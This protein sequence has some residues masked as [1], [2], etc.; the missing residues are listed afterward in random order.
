[1]VLI[2]GRAFLEGP[3]W[4]HGRLWLSDVPTGEVL[5][6]D[7]DGKVEVVAAIDG[8]PSGLG[9]LPDGTLLV[10]RGEPAAIMAVSPGGQVGVYVDLT[11]VASFAP[12]DMVVD[13]SGRA[14]VGTCDLAGIPSPR[15]SQVL[16]V[17]PDRSVSVVDDSMRFPNGSVV[18]PDGRT[19][20][21]AETFGEGLAAFDIDDDGV[22]G[23]KREWARVPGSYPDGICL[24]ADGAVWFADALGQAAVRVRQGGEVLDRVPTEQGCYACTLGGPDGR[25]LFLLTGRFGPAQ[26][27]LANRVGRVETVSVEVPGAGSP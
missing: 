6:V 24:D 3:R 15:P 8:A 2:E 5:S 9:W 12:N 16:L 23:A 10:A 1:M 18:T 25:T 26:A 14:W 21:V 22:A 27:Q 11:G 19:L 20:I 17:G 7:M 4:R 13:P